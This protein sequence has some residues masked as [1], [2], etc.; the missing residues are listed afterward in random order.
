MA[1]EG[2][3]LQLLVENVHDRMNGAPIANR[4]LIPITAPGVESIIIRDIHR[5]ISKVEHRVKLALSPKRKTNLPKTPREVYEEKTKYYAMGCF[6]KGEL[7]EYPY[8]EDLTATQKASFGDDS[9]IYAPGTIPWD[10]M[11]NKQKSYFSSRVIFIPN[12]VADSERLDGKG[13]AYIKLY[14]RNII[15][16]HSVGV[17][18]KKPGASMTNPLLYRTYTEESVNVYAKEGA[19][20]LMPLMAQ[21]G[22]MM[23]NQAGGYSTNFGVVLP[24][25]PQLI[26]V[27]YTFGLKE[28]PEDLKDAISL[29]TAAKAFESINLAYTQGLTGY[30]VQGFSAQ[31]GKGMYADVIERYKAEADEI[32]SAHYTQVSM[33]GW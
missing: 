1:L 2:E 19:I 9:S 17:F 14:E 10:M 30:S 4:E 27:D 33:T 29:L 13:R 18:L 21:G 12:K 7:V 28:I 22:M 8:W 20:Q 32:I 26:H 31:F 15:K 5:T 3:Q 11:T 6:P 24:R 23:S 16:V 25:Y